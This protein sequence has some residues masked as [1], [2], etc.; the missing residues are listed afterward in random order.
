MKN[1]FTSVRLPRGGKGELGQCIAA[2]AELISQLRVTV[3]CIDLENMN[4][5]LK[6]RL[7]SVPALHFVKSGLFFLNSV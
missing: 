6:R 5:E 1:F 2:L 3:N 7:T 4:P